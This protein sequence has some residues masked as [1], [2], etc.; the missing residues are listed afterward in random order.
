M[1]LPEELRY[2]QNSLLPQKTTTARMDGKL[3]VI[4]GATS[5]IGYETVK[6]FSKGGAQLVMVCRNEEKASKVAHELSVD[7]GAQVDFVIADFQKL[8][9]VQ[10]AGL[11][12]KEK[13]PNIH[14]LINNAGVFNRRRRLTP[15]GNEMTFGVIHLAAFLLTQ[16]LIENLKNGAPSRI[17]DVS[18]EAHRFGGLSLKDLTWEKRPYIGLLAYGAAKIAQIQT[19]IALAQK[20]QGSGITVNI[21]HPGAVRTNIGM[22]NGFFY[23]LYSRYILRWFLKNPTQSAESIYYLA[24]DPAMEN[25]T[26]KFFNQT[27]EEK[28]AWYSV[29]PEKRQAVWEQ[30]EALIEP[31]LKENDP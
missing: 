7:Y 8:S 22:N 16:L 20:L 3:C 31:Y 11:E 27:I 19:G 23:R 5:G 21:M 28:P 15:D 29:R 1:K 2:I 17:I 14:V 18:S 4:T 26:G 24:A 12:I 9:E 13:Y 6:R 30:S 10:R 25:V